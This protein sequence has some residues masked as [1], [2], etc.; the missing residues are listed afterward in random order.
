MFIL[1]ADGQIEEGTLLSEA[2]ME[3]YQHFQTNLNSAGGVGYI[4]SSS[5]RAIA[6]FMLKHYCMSMRHDDIPDAELVEDDQKIN[7]L[8]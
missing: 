3:V 4:T 7:E 1:T 5:L 6:R 2:E 8:A